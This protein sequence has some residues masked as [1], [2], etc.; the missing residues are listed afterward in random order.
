MRRLPSLLL[1]LALAC[2]GD[3]G[4]AVGADDD[5]GATGGSDGAD[6]GDGSTGT[7]ADGDGFTVEDGDC[8]DDDI[9]VNPAREEDVFDG[10]DNDCDGRIDEEWTGYTVAEQIEGGTS[11]LLIFD[12]IA[13]LEETIAL[14][15]GLVPYSLDHGLSDNYVV[16]LNESF[17]NISAG[18]ATFQYAPTAVAEVDA[19]GATTVLATFTD[20]THEN[21]DP[22]DDTF[23]WF[24]PIVREVATHP[25]GFY[26]AL[27]RGALTR[28]DADGGRSTLAEW[29]WD[30]NEDG[31]ELHAQALSVDLLTGEV[32]ILGLLGGFATWSEADGLTLHKQVDLE[33]WDLTRGVDVARMGA[34]GWR[35]MLGNFD[36]GEYAIYGWDAAAGDFDKQ[37]DWSNNRVVPLGLADDSDHDELYATAKGGDYRTIWRI[38]YLDESVDDAYGEVED[39]ATLW[40]I[41]SNY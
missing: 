13:R 4:P 38:R 9:G 32:A 41:A 39:G 8:D 27:E 19:S 24:G 29:Q 6:G 12:T 35:F 10:I 33:T 16:V 2:S 30:F 25:G 37:L 14:P 36:T 17:H 3:S 22:S 7:D 40:G 34:D 1:A 23:H 31:F 15:A 26:V 11:R 28:V 5:T 20:P 18:G 21:T